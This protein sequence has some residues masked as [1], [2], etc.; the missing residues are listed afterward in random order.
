MIGSWQLLWTAQDFSRDTSCININP[1]EN[2]SYSNNPMGR[3]DPIL[4]TPVQ[5][6]LEDLG[7]VTATPDIRSTQTIDLQSQL[8]K[9]IVVLKVGSQRASIQVW[10]DFQPHPNDARKVNVKFQKCRIRMANRVDLEIPFGFLGPTGWL[11][12]GYIDESLRITRGHK[13]SV[14]V[15]QRPSR[16]SNQTAASAV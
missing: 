3:A 6:I 4:P 13:G 12:T 7:W 8:V 11:R 16:S 2:Q 14:F 1:L 10:V 5:N 9:N 15:L